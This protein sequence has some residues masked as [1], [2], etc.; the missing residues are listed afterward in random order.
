MHPVVTVLVL[1]TREPLNAVKCVQA[2]QKQTIAG[3]L[4]ILVIDN[5]SDDDSIGI[6]RNR[7]AQYKNVR[8]LE[9]DHNAG[10]GGGNAIGIRQAAGD[11]LMINNPA[12]ILESDA[13]EK[14]LK[15]IEQDPTIGIVAPKLIHEDGTARSSARS[16]PHLS[17]VILKRTL[18]GS[19]RSKGVRRYLQSDV[20]PDQERTV[21]WVIGGCMMIRTA[22]M[23]E[24]GGFD[25]R[26]FLFF[27]DIDLCR[28]VQKAGKTV[29]YFPQAV[30]V[31]KKQRLSE[32]PLWKLPLKKTGRAHIASALKY[33][34]K[35]AGN[36]KLNTP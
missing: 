1:N 8:I 4:E 11:Y 34:W 2:L 5:H 22:L 30:A 6:L 20:S 28:R 7:L 26:F 10:F 36:D 23:R 19:E 16:F 17:D 14:M 31:D 33:F 12:K 9:A 13:L 35:W 29:L 21:D 18:P 32:M 24:L 15:R 25:P 3:K 27:E